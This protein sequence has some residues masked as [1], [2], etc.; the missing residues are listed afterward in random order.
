MVTVKQLAN[1]LRSLRKQISRVEI[2]KKK[3][4]KT[5][6]SSSKKNQQKEDL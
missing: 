2:Q 4:V 5:K 1:K 6:K 3:L